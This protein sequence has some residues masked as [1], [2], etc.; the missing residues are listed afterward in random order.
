M[1]QLPDDIRIMDL[2]IP[3]THD[4]ASLKGFEIGENWSVS[5][6]QQWKIEDQLTNGIRFLDLRV[7]IIGANE[8]AM[9]H[10]NDKIYDPYE[11]DTYNQLYFR[12]VVDV[13]V[14]WL[15]QHPRET[16][17]LSVK[18]EQHEYP[19][20]SSAEALTLGQYV[21]GILTAVNGQHNAPTN[22]NYHGMLH[23]N[24]T[25]ATLGQARGRLI[26]WCRFTKPQLNDSDS[27]PGV[28]FTAMSSPALDGTKGAVVDSVVNR[29]TL[30]TKPVAWVQ[31]AYNASTFEEKLEAWIT[32]ITSA[33]HSRRGAGTPTDRDLVFLNFG[34][35]A[36]GWPETNAGV[37]NPLFE[38]YLKA[39]TVTPT[40][41]TPSPNANPDDYLYRTG[42]GVIPLDFP[43][44]SLISTIIWLNF[45]RSYPIDMFVSGQTLYGDLVQEAKNA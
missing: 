32:S 20:L 10:A 36:G 44:Q 42:C 45:V 23:S 1:S 2:S 13:I 30:E 19:D 3:G 21:Y 24:W 8:L 38:K 27:Y 34:S 14:T 39:L 17:I 16:V 26:L 41:Y 25:D 7:Q 31:D 11:P 22:P 37:L 4:S 40:T 18:D 43:P 15:E 9:Y 12:K 28:D 5:A 6:T 29:T 33:I 35:Q